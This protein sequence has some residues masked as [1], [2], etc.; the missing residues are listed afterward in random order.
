MRGHHQPLAPGETSA[1]ENTVD[2]IERRFQTEKLGTE[3]IKSEKGEKLFFA[4]LRRRWLLPVPTAAPATR[5]RR[6]PHR[7]VSIVWRVRS[8][9][10]THPIPEP[11]SVGIAAGGYYSGRGERPWFRAPPAVVQGARPWGPQGWRPSPRAA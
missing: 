10:T 7:T 3:S 8:I 11:A 5:L 2:V 1:P 4:F 9:A 6:L